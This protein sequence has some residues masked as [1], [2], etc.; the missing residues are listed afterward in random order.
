MNGSAY[1]LSFKTRTHTEIWHRRSQCTA[2]S[3]YHQP[4]K[5]ESELC[6]LT[7]AEDFCT[8]LAIGNR[9]GSLSKDTPSALKKYQTYFC[10]VLK[11]SFSTTATNPHHIFVCKL[12]QGIQAPYKFAGGVGFRYNLKLNHNGVSAFMKSVFLYWSHFNQ[13]RSCLS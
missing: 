1:S 13:S 10:L 6:L 12:H 8:L 11:P 2:W 3:T 4:C 7:C 9:Q 5:Y